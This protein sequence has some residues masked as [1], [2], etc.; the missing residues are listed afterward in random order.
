MLPDKPQQVGL[1]ILT[2]GMSWP[3]FVNYLAHM[4]SIHCRGASDPES[5]HAPIRNSCR[6]KCGRGSNS[7]AVTIKRGLHQVERTRVNGGDAHSLFE[8]ILLYMSGFQNRSGAPKEPNSRFSR[9]IFDMSGH[10]KPVPAVSTA[11]LRNAPKHR[12]GKRE[13]HAI[14]R[15]RRRVGV[16]GSANCRGRTRR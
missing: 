1:P 11:R 15:L 12:V 10:R 3:I 16:K 4:L 9:Q 7:D 5:A 13:N 14:A 8:T 2:F 6:L